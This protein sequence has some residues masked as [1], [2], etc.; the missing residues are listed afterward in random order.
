MR[1]QELGYIAAIVPA[2]Y[3]FEGGSR[4]TTWR[5]FALSVSYARWTQ[6][7]GHFKYPDLV[8]TQFRSCGARRFVSLFT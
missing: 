5:L 4:P 3:F 1:W 8:H 6:N 2:H 7:S